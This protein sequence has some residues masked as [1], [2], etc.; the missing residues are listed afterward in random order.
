MLKIMFLLFTRHSQGTKRHHRKE[1]GF[2]FVEILVGA[3]LLLIAGF[4]I[5]KNSTQSVKFHQSFDRNMVMRRILDAAAS[6]ISKES[7]LFLPLNEPEKNQPRSIKTSQTKLSLYYSCHSETG[8]RLANTEGDIHFG[9]THE[10]YPGPTDVTKKPLSQGK[11]PSGADLA[12]HHVGFKKTG[13][14]Y[15]NHVCK[16]KDAAY[17]LFALPLAKT[18]DVPIW[19]YSLKKHPSDKKMKTLTDVVVL[20]PG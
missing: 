17:I 15:T 18:F 16:D 11:V 14:K 12:E 8:T 13:Q 2:S 7:S 3:S 4:M 5:A 20:S 19:V 9:I 6:H 10:A 1:A